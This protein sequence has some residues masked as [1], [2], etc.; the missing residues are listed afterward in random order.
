MNTKKKGSAAERKAMRL[1]EAAGY[2]CTRAA[3]SLGTFDVIA[4]GA[5]DVRLI[6]VK[7]GDRCQVSALERESMTL[8]VA[9][10]NT[11][12]EIWKFF[13]RRR[14]PLIEVLR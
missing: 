11:S 13:D 9:P 8:F 12:K 1:L 4:I 6:Q 14:D 3:G 2:R 10:A 5:A 7:C